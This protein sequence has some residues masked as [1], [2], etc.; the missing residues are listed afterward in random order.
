MFN[1]QNKNL[2]NNKINNS[3][4][5]SFQ[6]D[7]VHISIHPREKIKNYYSNYN[8]NIK[9]I[10]GSGNITP[11]DP[12]NQIYTTDTIKNT[13][14]KNLQITPPLFTKTAAKSKINNNGYLVDIDYVDNTN[15]IKDKYYP[16]Q[17]LNNVIMKKNYKN[18]KKI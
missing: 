17:Q 12:P 15:L 1:I 16:T 11:R 5:V 2:I 7:T 9:S 6:D 8:S 14:N 13:F 18:L 10:R 3:K 4:K